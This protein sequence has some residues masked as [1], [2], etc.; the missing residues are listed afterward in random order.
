MRESI[1]YRE[2]YEA[3]DGFFPARQH[4]SITDVACYMGVSKNTA[5]KMFPFIRK[6][7]GQS[8]CTK[9]QLARAIAERGIYID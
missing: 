1:L 4:L 5:K 6:R 7:D 2:E 3:I 9:G 8:G